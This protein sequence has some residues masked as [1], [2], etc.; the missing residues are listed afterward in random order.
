MTSVFPVQCALLFFRKIHLMYI[1]MDIF[2]IN[3]ELTSA[4]QYPCIAGS[5]PHFDDYQISLGLH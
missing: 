3:V 2:I 4:L 5:Y 1:E